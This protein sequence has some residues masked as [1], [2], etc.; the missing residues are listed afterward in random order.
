V[1]ALR[2]AAPAL[3]ELDCSYLAL[4][5]DAAVSP[6]LWAAPAMRRLRLANCRRLGPELLRPPREG[7]GAG[8]G[9]GEGAGGTELLELDLA[10]CRRAEEA[11]LRPGAGVALAARLPGCEV[12]LSR[13]R[14][15]AQHNSEACA[16]GRAPPPC[17]GDEA[18]SV[19]Q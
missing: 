2:A 7:E 18:H 4:L 15:L 16:D 14:T 6:L 17:S 13:G 19:P 8:E 3:A 5:T 11:L 1:Q 12:R 10:W 9:E